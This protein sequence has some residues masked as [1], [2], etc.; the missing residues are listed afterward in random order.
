MT[1]LNS[2]CKAIAAKWRLTTAAIFLITIPVHAAENA[3]MPSWTGPYFGLHGA[4]NWRDVDFATLKD[5]DDQG[6][7]FG[8]HIG[9]N[10]GLGPI[11]LGLEGDASYDGSDLSFSTDNGGTANLSADWNGS[12]R[13]RVGLPLGP[14]MVYG[15]AGWAWTETKFV[16][17]TALGATATRETTNDGIVYGLG[18]EGFVLPGISVRAEFL[19][20]DYGSEDFSSSI[21]TANTDKFDLNDRVFRLGI[22]VHLN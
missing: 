5:G 15:T 17:R 13:A 6:A 8:G 14:L 20:F 12:V 9:Y 7:Q 2:A 1:L 3:L 16:E 11:V 22:S 21:L 18:A 4:M 19:N 10:L